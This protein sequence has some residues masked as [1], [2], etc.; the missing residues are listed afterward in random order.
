MSLCRPKLPEVT[1][2]SDL[3]YAWRAIWNS[4]STTIGAVLALALGGGATTT[5]F[6][7]LNAVLLRPLPYPDSER[8]VE[9]WGNV[10]REQLERRGTSWPDYID[11]RDR[12]TSFD[13]IARNPTAD[14]DLYLPLVQRPRNFAA[15]LRSDGNL[16][17]A[18]GAA[19]AILQKAEPGV[20]VFDVQTL[21]HAFSRLPPPF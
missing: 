17:S 7:L 8:L 2:G 6:G 3:R 20:A 19:R 4:P 14:P 18:A 10:Q 11:W 16:A 9:V 13:G 1:V 12:A 15:L 21:V 5:I